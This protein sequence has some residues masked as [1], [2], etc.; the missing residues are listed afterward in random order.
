[1]LAVLPL[2]VDGYERMFSIASCAAMVSEVAGPSVRLA[3]AEK[4][5]DLS[6]DVRRREAEG[7][8]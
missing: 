3:L 4:A 7:R 5:V 8:S 6:D 1:M 2:V